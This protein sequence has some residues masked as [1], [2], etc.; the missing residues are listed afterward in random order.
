LVRLNRS[1]TE[2]LLKQ[3]PEAYRTQINDLLLTGLARVLCRWS[4]APS[5]LIDLEG[6]GREDL[7]EEIDLSRT[8]GW[9]TSLFPVRLTPL[10]DLYLDGDVSRSVGASIKAV[11]EQLRAVPNRGLGYGVLKHL[12]GAD[13][14]ASLEGLSKPRVT[15][16]YLGQFDQSFDAASLFVPVEEAGG[17]GRDPQAPMSN[18]LSIDGQ[19]YDGE[20]SLT[21]AYSRQMYAA[22]TIEALARDY[23]SELETIIAH[24]LEDASGGLTPSDV[25]LA[26][27]TQAQ[28][29]GLPV[30]ARE[31]EDIYPLSPMQ[32]GMLFHALHDPKAGHYV[33]QLSVSIEGLDLEKFRSAVAFVIAR[34]AI[35]RTSFVWEG[36]VP[37]PLQIVH[38]AVALPIV[39]LD[40]RGRLVGAEEL[41]N[42]A[43]VERAQGFST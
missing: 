23:R 17:R 25:P 1:T 12:C 8:V 7:F 10:V 3:A 29:D 34:H 19:V 2:Q 18:W 21:F 24:C 35:L 4:H 40:W 28:L 11:K 36:D 26:G 38:K 6:H 14:R 41:D 39:E 30:P 37:H 13:V 32:Q 27:L 16:N 5:I 22:E 20:L 33:N 15:F 43:I 42:L 9:F 31:I